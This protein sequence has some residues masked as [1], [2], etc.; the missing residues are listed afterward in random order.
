MQGKLFPG[1]ATIYGGVFK[2]RHTLLQTLDQKCSVLHE[3]KGIPRESCSL[4]RPGIFPK[5][6]LISDR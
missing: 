4:P 6:S 1:H 5:K 3:R 2:K